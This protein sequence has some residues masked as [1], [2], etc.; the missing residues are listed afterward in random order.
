MNE[1]DI[2]QCNS[3]SF[4]TLTM[5]CDKCDDE[6][7]GNIG[8]IASEGCNY[9]YDNDRLDCNECKSDYF[10]YTKGQC[11]PCSEEIEYCNKCH[12]DNSTE[13]L[14][15]DSCRNNSLHLS[16][17]K[18]TNKCEFKNC[19]EYPE[20]APGCIICDDKLEEYKSK[21]KCQSCKIGYFK[22][23]DDS[24]IYCRSEK[25]GGP[26]CFE[27]DYK[28]NDIL[29]ETENIKCIFCPNRYHALSSDGK[30][31]DCRLHL[32]FGCEKC[33]FTKN[34]I[35]NTEKLVCIE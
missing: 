1:S 34:E 15:C 27:C 25:Y 26:A 28:K 31:Y 23:K 19:E 17:N 7:Y 18:E 20:I 22:T 14:I 32:S 10:S 21:N 3:D 13:K 35:D 12:Y 5:W 2:C 6:Y 16:L 8:C 33:K 4:A 11:L 9:Y 24:C 29:Q 30:C